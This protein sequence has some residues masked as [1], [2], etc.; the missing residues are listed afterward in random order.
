MTIA[1]KSI[2]AAVGTKGVNRSDD[3]RVVQELLKY[4]LPDGGKLSVD[5]KCGTHTTDAIRYYQEKVLGW[6]GANVDGTINPGG[7]TWRALNGNTG[8]VCAAFMIDGYM[9][10]RQGSYKS[11]QLGS[12][13]GTI[14]AQGCALCT[15]TMAAT[16]IGAR[17][18]SWPSTLEPGALDPLTA[19]A[20]IRNAHGF[21]GSSLKLGDAAAALG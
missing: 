17:T 15:L 13:T 18:T 9:V 8:G 20:I 7:P 3:V 11:A 4:A 10:F 14:P 1:T 6:K 19:N 16:A 12:G 5:G 21:A 2:N